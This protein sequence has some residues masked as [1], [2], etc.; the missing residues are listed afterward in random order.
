M[1]VRPAVTDAI[2]T[3]TTYGPAGCPSACAQA[4]APGA[5][6]AGAAASDMASLP[7]ATAATTVSRA[8]PALQSPPDVRQLLLDPAGTPPESE[9]DD[10][11]AMSEVDVGDRAPD[12]VGLRSDHGLHEPLGDVA[13]GGQSSLGVAVAGAVL[14]DRMQLDAV[15]LTEGDEIFGRGPHEQ[16]IAGRESPLIERPAQ[17]AAVAHEADHREVIALVFLD[18]GRSEERR[19]GKGGRGRTRPATY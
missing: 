18:L 2:A 13:L 5:R 3:D 14:L 12:E 4:A 17:T 8:T 9:H 15:V 11:V 19:V 16:H 10:G 7:T 6:S 1:R